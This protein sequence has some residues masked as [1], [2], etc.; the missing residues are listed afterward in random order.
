M[1][2]S[3]KPEVGIII[4]NYNGFSDTCACIESIRKNT[5]YTNY[6]IYL[7]DNKSTDGKNS[8]LK[9][10]E[11]IKFIQSDK[12]GGFAY[13]NNLGIKEAKKDDCKYYVLL[14]NDTEVTAGWLSKMIEVAGQTNDEKH[15]AVIGGVILNY[16]DQNKIDYI[17]GYVDY[18]KGNAK[19]CHKGETIN[20]SLISE[21]VKAKDINGNEIENA[22]DTQFIT[23]C[24]L[25]IPAKLYDKVGGISEDYFMYF[26]DVDFC[27]RAK[28]QSAKL[29]ICS[30]VRI[31]HKGGA[32]VGGEHTKFKVFY[33]IRNQLIFIHKFCP[34]EWLSDSRLWLSCVKRMIKYVFWHKTDLIPEIWR[35]WRAGKQFIKEQ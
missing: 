24:L 9:K 25:M 8:E 3:E 26:E 16:C 22:F 32:T 18:F 21:Y 5:K 27:E 34:N 28:Q 6:E 1:K 15:Q 2:N 19:E 29:I 20:D 17:G 10:I 23:G 31:F 35:G 7:V 33:D 30:N 4:V 12:N 13:A 11:R 14:N